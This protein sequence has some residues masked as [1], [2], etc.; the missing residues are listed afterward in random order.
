[1][2][3]LAIDVREVRNYVDGAWVRGSGAVL[4]SRDPAT[5]DLVAT[6]TSS[7]VSEGSAAWAWAAIRPAAAPAAKRS[8]RFIFVLSAGC[9]GG[10]YKI[11]IRAIKVT[12]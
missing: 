1:M 4:E 8:L 9:D 2:T 5:G 10:R 12:L 7:T 6:T 11:T 3:N